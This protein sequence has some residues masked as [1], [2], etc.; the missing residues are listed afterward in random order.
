VSGVSVQRWPGMDHIGKE[1]STSRGLA[2]WCSTKRMGM[3]RMG[4]STDVRMVL[5]IPE[6]P[7]V[8]LFSATMPLEIRQAL[9]QYLKESS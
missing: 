8:V 3:L 7:Q 1:R 5:D 9:P 6:Q 4:S 2:A